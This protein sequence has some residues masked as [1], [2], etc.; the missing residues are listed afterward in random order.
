MFA[1]DLDCP[2]Q[3]TPHETTRVTVDG[4]TVTEASG[5]S[6]AGVVWDYV[7]SDNRHD[8]GYRLWF[9]GSIT[10]TNTGAADMFHRFRYSVPLYYTPY[11]PATVDNLCY[12]PSLHECIVYL[13]VLVPA[14]ETVVLDWTSYADF[15]TYNGGADFNG[16]YVVDSSDMGLLYAAW[17]T[18]DPAFDLNGD[19]VVDGGD[20]GILLNYWTDTNG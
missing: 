13:E 6:V 1:Q 2:T 12:E 4:I 7:Y 3:L 5:E 19:G 11:V 20:L 14:G 16:D 9:E 10:L 8:V 18:D 17:G 15:G